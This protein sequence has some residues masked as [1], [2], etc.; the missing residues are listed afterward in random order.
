MCFRLCS[1]WNFLALSSLSLLTADQVYRKCKREFAT[2]FI[3]CHFLLGEG[4]NYLIFG[5]VYAAI[6]QFLQIFHF[7]QNIFSF[8]GNVFRPKLKK[9]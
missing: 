4:E 5:F 3:R 6:V 8:C 1:K 2:G 9:S 7:L